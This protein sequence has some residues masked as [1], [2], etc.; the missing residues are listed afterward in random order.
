MRTVNV[1]TRELYDPRKGEAN[2]KP[3]TVKSI[4]WNNSS[5]RK[6]LMNHLHWAMN[7]E[8]EVR[9][10]PLADVPESN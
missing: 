5:D 8:H 6:W 1:S 10:V 2:R 3:A 4:C 9:L 7:N